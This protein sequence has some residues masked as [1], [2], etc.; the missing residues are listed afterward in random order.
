MLFPISLYELKLSQINVLIN[1][2][3]SNSIISTDNL[4]QKD[5]TVPW[6]EGKECDP[7]NR[8]NE[9][10]YDVQKHDNRI[11]IISMPTPSNFERVSRDSF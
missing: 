10:D 9:D 5:H 1:G 7:N 2:L 11:R 6:K 4:D 3:T 8:H